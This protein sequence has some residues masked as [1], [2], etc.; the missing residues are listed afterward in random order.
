MG[1]TL[2]IEEKQDMLNRFEP[3]EK[4]LLSWLE[5]S[6]PDLYEKILFTAKKNATNC[7][8]GFHLFNY[9]KHT[10]LCLVKYDEYGYRNLKSFK[11]DK[12]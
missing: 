10:H 8:T 7:L 1:N 6:N 5:K 12:W 9:D 3:Y 2:T 11:V 4:G